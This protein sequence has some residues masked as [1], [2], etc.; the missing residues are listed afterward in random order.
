MKITELMVG[1]WVN[2]NPYSQK[3]EKYVRVTPA[4]IN[5]DESDLARITPIPLTADILEKN[6]FVWTAYGVIFDGGE[7]LTLQQCGDY[8]KIK[9]NQMS[10]D[11]FCCIWY[12]HELQH[13]LRL[14]GIDKLAD[15]FQI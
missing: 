1:D 3:L 14:C 11:T 8:W 10:N 12:V 4:M 13:A 9:P 5:Y 6:R 15:N 2:R 7:D